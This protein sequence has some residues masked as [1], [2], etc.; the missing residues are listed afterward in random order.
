MTESEARDNVLR[1]IVAKE[2]ARLR[3]LGYSVQE[4]SDAVRITPYHVRVFAAIGGY[5]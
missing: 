5:R 4:V 3:G 1:W 2:I